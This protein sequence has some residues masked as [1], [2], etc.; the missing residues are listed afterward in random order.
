MFQ[1][2]GENIASVALSIDRGGLYRY[3]LRTDLTEAEMAQYRKAMEA[4]TQTP[5][6]I[7]QAEDGTW[8]TSEITLLGGDAAEDYDPEVSYGFW[9]QGADAAA[10]QAD[11]RAASQESIDPSWTARA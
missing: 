11:M 1:I 9:V 10:W 2:T 3:R 5:A 8:Y 7:S 4:G 6:A